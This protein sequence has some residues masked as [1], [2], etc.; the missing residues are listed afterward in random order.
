[1]QAPNA[2]PLQSLKEENLRLKKLLPEAML[3]N[4]ALKD[5]ISGQFADVACFYL[6]NLSTPTEQKMDFERNKIHA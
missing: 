3:D 5:I 4:V 6:D 1:M 2:K